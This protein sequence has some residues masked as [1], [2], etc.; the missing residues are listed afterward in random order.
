MLNLT[1][2]FSRP[3]SPHITIYSFQITSIFSIWHRITG[4]S[5]ILFV[6]ISLLFFK[7][8]SYKVLMHYSKIIYIN[9]W[10]YNTFIINLILFFMYHLLNG[11]RHI[12]WD[13]GYN[14]SLNLIKLSI[15]IIIIS[16]ITIIIITY[17]IIF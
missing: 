1:K 6:I 5:L 10:V 3:L 17:K 14:L 12:T 9:S 15:Q 4:T 7:I 2:S 16:L 8:F 11:L 13:L